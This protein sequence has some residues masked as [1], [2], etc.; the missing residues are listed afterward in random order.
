MQTNFG[1]Q[2]VSYSIGARVISL[3]KTAGTWS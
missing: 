3:G 1:T 2:P